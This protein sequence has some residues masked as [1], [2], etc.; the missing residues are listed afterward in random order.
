MS[1][2]TVID[3]V[4]TNPKR[5]ADS[6]RVTDVANHLAKAIADLPRSSTDMVAGFI[7]AYP[8]GDRTPEGNAL[9][10]W[11]R[12]RKPVDFIGV[13]SPYFYPSL[14]G[15][16]DVKITAFN[17]VIKVELGDFEATVSYPAVVGDF[18]RSLFKGYYPQCIK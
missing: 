4:G 14:H 8:K 11:L 15:T 7:A 17:D 1:N 2:V 18:V 10:K 9:T 3:K 6:K 12:Q 16:E 13:L 5:A